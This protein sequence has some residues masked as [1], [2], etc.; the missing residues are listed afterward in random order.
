MDSDSETSSNSSEDILSQFEEQN[1]SMVSLVKTLLSTSTMPHIFLITI[2]STMLYIAAKVDS[3]TIFA[4][5]TFA[6]LSISYCITALLSK[7]PKVSSWITL[8][9][10]ED[11]IT[12]SKLWNNFSKFRI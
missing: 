12:S 10:D 4:S 1:I 11:E 9:N 7:N 5:M 3:L 8:S 2:L 6:S